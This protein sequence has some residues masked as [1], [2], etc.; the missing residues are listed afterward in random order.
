MFIRGNF[1]LLLLQETRTDGS[2]K[3]IKKWQKISN[4]KQIYLT[5]FGTRAVG[6]GIVVRNSEVFKVH[7]SFHDPLG[8]YV[9]IIGD[10]EEG[11]FLVLSFYSPSIS[12]EIRD[13]VINHI[14]QQ[15]INL[16]QDLPQFLVIGGDTN[17]PFNQLDKQGGNTNFKQEAILAFETLKQRFALFDSF[18]VKNPGK[19]E[20]TWEVLN[21]VIIRE[22][23]DVIFVSNSLQDYVTETG[24]IPAHKTCS[25][26]GIPFIKIAG[27]GI[28][29]RG[30][31]IWKFNNN[32]LTDSGF[33]SEMKEN[34]PK[35]ILE[36]ETDLP[37]KTGGQ[38]GFL[39]HKVGEFSRSYGAKL[40]KSKLLLKNNL[41]KELETLSQNL[42]E[43]NK[44][45]FKAL[46]EQLNAIIETE[47]QGSILRSLCDEYEQGE[48]IEKYRAKQKTISR[49]KLSDGSFSSDPKVILE[50]CRYFYQKLYSKNINVNPSLHPEFFRNVTTPKLTE[51]QK[52]FCDSKLTFQELFK[53]LESFSK[54][55]SPG[56]D[57]ITAEFYRVFWDQIKE[58]LFLVYEESFLK[59]ILP[60]CLRTG[61]VTLLEKKGKDRSDISNWRPI[62]L[63]NLD[64]K[65]LTK[66][67]GQRLK[68]VLPSLIHKDQNGFIPGGNIF[69]SAHTIRD[70]LF[71]CKKENLDLILLALDYTK[72]FDSVDF[73]FIH[74]T[75]RL[76]NFGENFRKWVKLIF[77]EGKSCIT[78]N[79]RISEKFEIHRS[80]RQGDP[81]SPLIFILGLQVLFITLRSDENI[82]GFKIENSELKLTSYADDASYFLRDKKSAELLLSRIDN[83]SKISGLEVNR[84]KSECL[85]LAFEVGLN[86]YREQFLGIPL[87]ENLKILGHFYGK[88][89][90]ACNFHN[91]YN[92][93]EKIKKILNIWKQR[94][95]TLIGK[96][97]LIKSLST[98]LFVFNSQIDTPPEDFIKLVEEL[99]KNFLWS[100]APK[101]AHNAIIATYKCGGLNYKDLQSF[102]AAINVKFLQKL[103][104]N[105]ADGHLVLPNM[106]IKKFFNIPTTP[107]E[108][109]YYWDFFKNNL[110][111]LNCL[112]KIPRKNKFKGHPFYY[113]ALKTFEKISE[114]NR[115]KIENI[116]SIP[117]W[118]NRNLKT[119]FDTEI[120]RAGFNFIK[121]LFPEN[122]PLA[123]YNGL[124]RIKLRKLR[125]IINRVPYSWRDKIEQSACTF[126][127][128]KPSR[129]VK[130]KDQDH[131]VE[132]IKPEQIYYY[133]IEPK[134]KMSVGLRKWQDEM[135]ITESDIRTG[136]SF[137]RKCSK[138][139]FDQA[140]QFKI[141]TQILPT[142]KYLCQYR[143]LE[144]NLC[145]KCNVM[146]DTVLHR[147]WQCQLLQPY[148][149]KIF[150][151]LSQKCQIQET[152]SL[153]E[154]LFGFSNNLGLNHALLELKKLIFYSWDPNIQVNTFLDLFIL[155]VRKLII[156]E[157]QFINSAKTYDQLK[158]KW[159]NFIEIYD[160]NGPDAEYW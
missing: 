71:Y 83:F 158:S 140:F 98:S 115:L 144:S 92:K 113:T 73:E 99:H 87:V 77:N 38:W 85:I 33:V 36:A 8:R 90:L 125:N 34:I 1:D 45:K 110:H 27:F 108:H 17:T 28:P 13:F 120:S 46:Q 150:F 138:L 82:R 6:A 103:L 22:R 21:P 81:I 48:N 91:F 147:L 134:I 97:L 24:V 127:A 152:I 54:N 93:L 42:N 72:A 43:E 59:G 159:D 51:N 148:I 130:I 31:G 111:I 119:T 107:D 70:I 84:T 101:I 156:K 105:P 61:V 65:L 112:V 20:F 68:L 121:D 117:I 62:T 16:G 56:L 40:K 94:K 79:G 14:Y 157:K 11:K 19:R 25:D 154:Y 66:T 149:D 135:G 86:Q 69:Y 109:P 88:S 128:V 132:T 104:V 133:L 9:G 52:Q 58:K 141:M 151:F 95:L 55:K 35:W 153:K 12:R 123:N 47:I 106:W 100:G 142:N 63:L 114:S 76:F 131:Y 3:E 118:F 10:H 143:V 129:V 155:T 44:G 4:S 29:S 64:Y 122:L 32:L 18:R 26:H 96:T 126:L 60:E 5:E 74:K 116:I 160:F 53:C 80:T 37:N 67:L 23:L 124:N 102:I 145:N 15:L 41:E 2:E 146:P 137:A 50:E 49:L 57:G 136:F 30:P 139:T 89:E 75:F 78:N 7:R 39:K